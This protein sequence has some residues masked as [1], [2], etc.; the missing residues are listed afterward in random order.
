MAALPSNNPKIQLLMQYIKGKTHVCYN[1]TMR[2][3]PKLV[4]SL[5]PPDD[6]EAEAQFVEFTGLLE[7]MKDAK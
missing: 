2:S 1:G 7:E 5:C 4:C 6:P 3:Y